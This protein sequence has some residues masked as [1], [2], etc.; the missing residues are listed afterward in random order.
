MMIFIIFCFGQLLIEHVP[1]TVGAIYRRLAFQ[2]LRN[3]TCR[4]GG[5]VAMRNILVVEDYRMDN[6]SYLL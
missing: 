4:D 6:A 2:L 1:I 5:H 3:D